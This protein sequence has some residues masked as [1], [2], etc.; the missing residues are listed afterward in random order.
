MKRAIGY[1]SQKFS[2]YLDLTPAE[3]LAFFAGAYGCGA[4]S[5]AAGSRP[6]WPRP[7]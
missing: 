4:P 7:S 6:P 5:G 2:L 1:M 3:N